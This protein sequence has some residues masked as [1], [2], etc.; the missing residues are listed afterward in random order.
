M[1]VHD[2]E[3]ILRRARVYTGFRRMLERDPALALAGYALDPRE[4][5][6]IENRD[7]ETLTGLGADEDLVAWWCIIAAP[8]P[9]PAAAPPAALFGPAR[10]QQAAVERVTHQL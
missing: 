4:Q 1:S 5:A 3:H 8:E 7:A 2:L 10:P 9:A 6:G